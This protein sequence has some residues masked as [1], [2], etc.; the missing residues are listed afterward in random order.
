MNGDQ[1]QEVQNMLVIDPSNDPNQEYAP[2]N[3]MDGGMFNH[4]M[5]AP[6]HAHNDNNLVPRDV[7]VEDENERTQ[8]SALIRITEEKEETKQGKYIIKFI[9]G[10]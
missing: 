6:Y 4:N 10:M 7:I 5:E 3:E 9:S 2:T 1:E 8:D